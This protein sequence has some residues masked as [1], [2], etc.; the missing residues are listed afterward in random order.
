MR[1][2][3][4]VTSSHGERMHAFHSTYICI[5][6]HKYIGLLDNN[7]RKTM[8]KQ[9]KYTTT[10]TLVRTIKICVAEKVHS[11]HGVQNRNF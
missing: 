3:P 9:Y 7:V 10:V 2:P 1:W 5:T 6:H 11:Y 4:F 8:T